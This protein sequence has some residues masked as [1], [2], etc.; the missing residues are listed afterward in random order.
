MIG[1]ITKKSTGFTQVS[2]N[3]I[4]D[5]N[6][7]L[8]AKGLYAYIFSKPDGWEFS[9]HRIAKETKDGRDSIRNGLKELIQLGYIDKIKEPTGKI[10]YEVNTD[11]NPKTEKPKDGKTH[12]GKTR[13]L[14][15]TEEE[16]NIYKE[17]NTNIYS[18]A[19]ALPVNEEN[20]VNKLISFFGKLNPFN[21][22]LYKN[23]TQ[24]LSCKNL[25]EKYSLEQ[26]SD[27]ID[28][29]F[30]N[31]SDRFLPL[32]TTPYELVTKFAKVGHFFEKQKETENLAYLAD[33]SKQVKKQKY[34]NN[35][36][37]E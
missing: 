13:P 19:E 6:L 36:T 34:E 7:S 8:K 22:N 3:I 12:C 37:N 9:S 10:K 4:N 18:N 25:L 35:K 32:I 20:N 2:N 14:S 31:K 17:I 21:K 28:F 33:L 15:N 30:Q 24:R 23:K 1:E 27:L 16:S 11:K 29:I 26:L 5:P